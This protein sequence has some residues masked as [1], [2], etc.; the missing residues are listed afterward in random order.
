MD[1]MIEFCIGAASGPKE[2]ISDQ[3]IR[4]DF[5]EFFVPFEL[6]KM[7]VVDTDGLFAGIFR[8]TFQDTL[9]TLVHAVSKGNH[10][11]IINEVFRL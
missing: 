2:I 9:L 5:G 4:W 8:K 11:A 7:I 3:V 1:C 10:E 6:P